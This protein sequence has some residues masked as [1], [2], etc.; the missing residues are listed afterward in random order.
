MLAAAHDPRTYCTN[1]KYVIY[2]IKKDQLKH[3]KR[4][5]LKQVQEIN[6]RR[7]NEKGKTCNRETEREGLL[8]R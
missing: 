5:I 1:V 7:G 3:E 8:V 6:C 2:K 4:R